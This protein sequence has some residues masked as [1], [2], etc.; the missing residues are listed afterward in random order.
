MLF[1]I[2]SGNKHISV[3]VAI[4]LSL[5]TICKLLGTENEY[6]N[7]EKYLTCDVSRNMVISDIAF[8]NCN[9]VPHSSRC[10]ESVDRVSSIKQTRPMHAS[11]YG[12]MNV[13]FF[14]FNCK[15]LESQ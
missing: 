13:I 8:F 15:V 6:L 12:S 14:R 3:W 11:V 1:P 10:V 7:S 2:G 4:F 9:F 5:V